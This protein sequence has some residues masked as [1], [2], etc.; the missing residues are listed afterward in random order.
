MSHRRLLVFLGVFSLLVFGL[1][2]G[3]SLLVQADLLKTRGHV[4]VGIA[5]IPPIALYLVL[6]LRYIL[7]V[8][9]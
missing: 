7:R 6:S 5:G 2:V 8:R 1:L 3:S 4:T 9:G